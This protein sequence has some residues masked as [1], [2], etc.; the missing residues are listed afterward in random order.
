MLFR[1]K[2]IY[3]HTGGNVL[4]AIIAWPLRW[5][6]GAV[7]GYNF[8]I[9]LVLFFN[10]VGMRALAEQVGAD[11]QA[12]RLGAVFFAFNPFALNEING[13]RP[14]QVVF[15][16][17]L[18]YL[19]DL[20]RTGEGKSWW[21]PARAGVWLALT[22]LMYW[23]YA[24]FGGLSAVGIVAWR[25]W[26]PREG[27]RRVHLV[28]RHGFIAVVALLICGPFAYPMVTAGSEVPGMLDVSKWSGG[29]W[30]PTTNEG[31]SVGMYVFDPATR[32]S[33]F[34]VPKGD[35]R[36]FLPEYLNMLWVQVAML[37]GGLA[38]APRR[39]RGAG[40]AK[41]GRAHV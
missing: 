24:F 15:S 36:I 39:W 4:D 6:F 33:G 40:V 8:W 21:V 9:V 18:L 29:N 14:T 23:F 7:A 37:V 3:L 12:A 11:R 16:F 28:L 35:G 38:L 17:L 26:A 13:G 31:V 1:S 22:A 20:L 25:L 41:I 19:L 27:D 34:W 2:D 30:M 10:Y 32:M 5:V